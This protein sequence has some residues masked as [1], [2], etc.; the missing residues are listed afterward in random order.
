MS[1]R[2]FFVDL[3][4]NQ[5]QVKGFVEENRTAA[6][7]NPKVGQR[8]FNTTDNKS[9]VWDGSAWVAGKE[10]TAGDGLTLTGSE[11]A[12][13]NPLSD[14]EAKWIADQ[15]FAKLFTCSISASPANS[16]F[17]GTPIDITFTLSTKYDSK[18]VDLDEVPTGWNRTAIGTYT[19]AG[20]I[21]SSTGGSINSG[22]VSCKYQG[23]T[24]TASAASAGNTKYSFYIESNKEALTAE[25]LNA[26]VDSTAAKISTSNS[27][28][29][30]K[31]YTMKS[32][33]YLYF[34]VANT[35]NLNDVQAMN[36]SILQSKTPTQITR[37]NYGTYKVYR[38]GA[39]L[40][41]MEQSFTIK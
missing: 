40:G 17:A 30:D 15:L 31:K 38:S 41:A 6:P 24:K 25:D 20:Q 19:K 32:A 10:Y 37:T 9:Y 2:K 27:I 8:Y 23:N 22:S 29:G 11:F 16:V 13:K 4:M 35:S 14:A 36:V 26:I 5:N 28:T 21:T 12:V 3:N 33:A 34:V 39:K 18:A 7:I 1:E